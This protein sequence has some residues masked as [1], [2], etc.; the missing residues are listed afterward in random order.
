MLR[1]RFDA[2]L[3]KITNNNWFHG[4]SKS[5]FAG[6][7]KKCFVFKVKEKKLHHRFYGFLCNPRP[8]DKSYEVCILVRHAYKEKWE[9]DETCLKEIV[10]IMTESRV[11][12]AINKFFGRIQ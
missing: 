11:R 4:W 7:Y 1:T 5:E 2:W 3:D 10:S 9:T 6:M 12:E 8:C